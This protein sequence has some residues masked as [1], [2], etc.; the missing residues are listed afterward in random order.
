M[1]RTLL[2]F[3]LSLTFALPVLATTPHISWLSSDIT[4]SGNTKME[5]DQMPAFSQGLLAVSQ[6]SHTGLSYGFIDSSGK[7]AISPSYTH[8]KAFSEGL[9][10]AKDKVLLSEVYN[11]LGIT[12]YDQPNFD[13]EP[14]PDPS[15]TWVERY[16]YIDK[17]GRFVI[18]PTFED[19]YGF[20]NGLAA[21][22]ITAGEWGFVDTS[23]ILVLQGYTWA[24]D[25]DQEGYAIVETGEV[26]GL[27]DKTGTYV[28]DPLFNAIGGGDGLYPIRVNRLFGLM[29][30]QGELVRTYQYDNMGYFKDELAL[31][32]SGGKWGFVDNLGDLVISTNAD[33]GFHFQ[34]GLAWLQ[35]QG[36]CYYIDTSGRTRLEMAGLSEVTSFSSG[37]ARGKSGHFYGFF[38]KTGKVILDYQYRD[39][40]PVSEGIGLVFDGTQWG[41]F[42]PQHRHSD[43]AEP[44]VSQMDN[45]NLIPTYFEGVDLSAPIERTQFASLVVTLFDALLPESSNLYYGESTFTLPSL[46]ENPFTDSRDPQVR[47]A[48]HLNLTSGL[49]EDY[50][51]ALDTI[52]REQAA[53]MLVTLL[54]V[55][56]G[57]TVD[58]QEAPLFED[59]DEI[60]PWAEN[61]VYI[62][63]QLGILTGVGDNFFAPHDPISGESALIMALAL[64]N[65]LNYRG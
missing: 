61:N 59:H 63:A 24:H 52:T 13:G 46:V 6:D 5:H 29:N 17:T 21:V 55:L 36:T 11:R 12:T 15:E 53:T 20:S 31:A 56:T 37:Y 23:G 45:L 7:F 38:D 60:S 30:T 48:Y 25:F 26:Q 44:Y 65:H 42:Y 51:G 47:R 18:P 27:I 19:A 57:E 35:H 41:L 22:E 28:I 64:C 32:E 14:A 58:R 34:D 9:A 8:V 39:A 33:V 3:T 10:P 43:W 1:R 4:P 2:A 54:Q 16:G 50:F 40:I 49:S 62:L